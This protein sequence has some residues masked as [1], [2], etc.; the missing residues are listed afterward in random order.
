MLVGVSVF[1]VTEM[2]AMVETSDPTAIT[3]TQIGR[4][5]AG[6]STVVDEPQAKI[7]AFE[8]D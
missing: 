1:V 2:L 4:Y 7:A 8:P 5:S 6:P 3:L